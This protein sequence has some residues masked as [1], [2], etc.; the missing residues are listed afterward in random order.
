MI[1]PIVAKMNNKV[2][3]LV[4]MAA[5]GTKI[6]ELLIQQNYLGGKLAGMTEKDLAEAN[7]MNKKDL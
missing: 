4:L 3:F 7:V 2:K 6:D 5:P 1:A